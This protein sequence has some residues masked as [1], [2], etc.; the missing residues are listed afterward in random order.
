M[1]ADWQNPSL[2]RKS[3]TLRAQREGDHDPLSRIKK[4]KASRPPPNG[5]CVFDDDCTYTNKYHLI[6]LPP[7]HLAK[8]KQT[9]KTGGWYGQVTQSHSHSRHNLL[10]K[11]SEGGAGHTHRRGGG[12]FQFWRI[13]A[14]AKH[15]PTHTQ[16]T[17]AC[18]RSRS[19]SL[20]LTAA[21]WCPLAMRFLQFSASSFYHWP[22]G[23][24]KERSLTAD[25]S[26]HPPHTLH[27]P[28]ISA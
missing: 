19:P 22:A 26:T 23:R 5:Q 21:V 24:V 28:W 18:S 4:Y 14:G 9:E 7:A 27:L 11:K 25:H 17:K 3:P 20:V 8:K 2:R 15:P 1:A 10:G 16:N 12:G 6:P 13:N